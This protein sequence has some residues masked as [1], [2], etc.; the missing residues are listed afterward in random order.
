MKYRGALWVTFLLL[1]L[2]ACRL[3]WAVDV[4][5]LKGGDIGTVPK[6]FVYEK[7]IPVD[8]EVIWAWDLISEP[9]LP[10]VRPLNST[11][12]TVPEPYGK[13]ERS[14]SAGSPTTYYQIYEDEVGMCLNVK[15]EEVSQ[16]TYNPNMKLAYRWK[17]DYYGGNETKKTWLYPYS[18]LYPHKNPRLQIEFQADVKTSQGTGIRHAHTAQQWLDEETGLHVYLQHYYYDSRESFPPIT[19]GYDPKIHKLWVIV[20]MDGKG[21]YHGLLPGTKPFSNKTW[22]DYAAFG[23]DQSWE[24]FKNIIRYLNEEHD[25]NMSL[26]RDK[27]RLAIFSNNFEMQRGYPGTLAGKIKD[28]NIRTRY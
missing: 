21:S 15:P 3:S 13:Y 16:E 1:N 19:S 2:A 22:D 25:L 8:D 14:R 27:W 10:V 26:N 4:Y 11:G 17:A 20:R 28:T 5:H 6:D 12:L 24:H 9:T 23:I 7:A 18:N